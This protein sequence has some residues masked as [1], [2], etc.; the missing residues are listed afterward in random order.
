M[1]TTR[2]S[3]ERSPTRSA[4][5]ACRRRATGSPPGAPSPRDPRPCRR[6]RSSRTSRTASRAA[7]TWETA[8]CKPKR[9]SWRTT[10]ARWAWCTIRGRTRRGSSVAT[11]GWCV[12][13]PRTPT[14]RPSPPGRTDTTRWRACGPPDAVPAPTASCPRWLESSSLSV[15]AARS[16]AWRSRPTAGT[17]SPW[18]ATT[19]TPCSCGTGKSTSGEI[20]LRRS[21][22][23]P[24]YKLPC[25]RCGARRST[26]T[27]DSSRRASLRRGP[28]RRRSRSPPARPRSGRSRPSRT[29]AR[30]RKGK[31]LS[32]RARLSSSPSARSTSSCGAPTATGG[33]EDGRFA[34]TAPRRSRRT[35]RRFCPAGTFWWARTTAASRFSTS[36]NAR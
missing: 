34:S 8:C 18:G 22:P 31:R 14:A 36:R 3:W 15:F 29:G 13:S 26:R 20:S 17:C 10:S 25:P 16:C 23:C 32:L 33:G 28:R 24:A 9:A 5:G 11:R 35:P 19:S 4:A 12:R 21:C 7:A 1:P 2:G 27:G 6:S 30:G